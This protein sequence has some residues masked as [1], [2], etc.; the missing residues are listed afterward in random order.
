MVK[1]NS[2]I[3]N[4]TVKRFLA[5]FIVVAMTV[6][7]ITP[8][9]SAATN[10][11]NGLRYII[12]SGGSKYGKGVYI[13]SYRGSKSS[14]SIP[15]KINGYYVVSV[16]LDEEYLKSINI[17]KA[18]GLKHLD[19]SENRLTSINVTKN[20]KLKKLDVSENRLKSLNVKNNKKLID[21]DVSENRLTSINI[22]KNTKLK[23]LDLSKNKL[24]S[25]NL[26]YNKNL[27]ELDLSKNKLTNLNVS[28]NLQLRELDIEGNSGLSW[29]TSAYL[30]NHKYMKD[31]T[32]SNG[33]E[34]DD[35]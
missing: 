26:T 11:Y 35:D 6:A 34:S 12:K 7:I 13:T 28:K 16:D 25:I 5:A 20:K 24:K 18:T 9:V 14:I 33:K 31:F 17:K 21:L 15:K 3:S 29:F 2:I 1:N 27:R 4:N 10:T 30:T 19:V 8:A 23:E 32:D 22:K